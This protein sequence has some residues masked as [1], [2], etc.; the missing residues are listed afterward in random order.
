[1][2]CLTHAVTLSWFKLVTEDAM[3]HTT[4]ACYLGAGML[5]D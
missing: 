4:A 5:D 3:K 1:M 2:T